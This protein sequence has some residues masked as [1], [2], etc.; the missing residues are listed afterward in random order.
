MVFSLIYELVMLM[1]KRQ[2]KPRFGKKKKKYTN[3]S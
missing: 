2:V 3:I 1:K